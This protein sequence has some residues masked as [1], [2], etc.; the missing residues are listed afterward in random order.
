MRRGSCAQDDAAGTA[1]HKHGMAKNAC[2]QITGDCCWRYAAAVL[3]ALLAVAASLLTFIFNP[4]S[5][6]NDVS[7][8]QIV[9]S[10]SIM[11]TPLGEQDAAVIFVKEECWQASSRH[12]GAATIAAL[13]TC[14][15]N[16]VDDMATDYV[17]EL[18]EVTNSSLGL[19]TNVVRTP[20]AKTRYAAD[21]IMWHEQGT[22][23][24]ADSIVWKLRDG[25]CSDHTCPVII[26]PPPSMTNPTRSALDEADN[27]LK[28][29]MASAVCAI[30]LCVC[31]EGRGSCA[32][33]NANIDASTKT[34][35]DGKQHALSGHPKE[36]SSPW[37]PAWSTLSICT[38]NQC[39]T[40]AKIAIEADVVSNFTHLGRMVMA[41]GGCTDPVA[42]GYVLPTV[43]DGNMHA[44]ATPPSLAFLFTVYPH[45]RIC[46][47]SPLPLAAHV[48]FPSFCAL[49]CLTAHDGAVVLND[50][51]LVPHRIPGLHRHRLQP[52]CDCAARQGVQLPRQ[53]RA[54]NAQVAGHQPCGLMLAQDR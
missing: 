50:R 49:R 7:A 48:D 13:S 27:I 24:A 44:Q 35:A 43:F 53:P 38:P 31:A 26:V 1:Q 15:L 29:N 37:Y 36:A 23:A 18:K 11:V 32:K 21:L 33:D 41:I 16:Q 39:D 8:A 19:M 3:L 52:D 4:I 9:N 34:P 22:Q 40:A 47:H 25:N 2:S 5:L 12:P 20:P 30:D 51:L 54:D 14:T 17:C 10:A 6:S 42:T 46:S 45:L 28:D